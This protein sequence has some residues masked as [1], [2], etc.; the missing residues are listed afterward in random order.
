MHSLMK[1]H[2]GP[3]VLEVQELPLT[4]NTVEIYGL[5]SQYAKFA[6]KKLSARCIYAAKG[7]KASQLY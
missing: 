6:D 4:T 5:F 3:F 7:K 2:S 1:W